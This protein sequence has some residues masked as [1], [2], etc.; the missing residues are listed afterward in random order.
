MTYHGYV[1]ESHEVQTDDGYLLTI[2]RIPHGKDNDDVTN[3]P[4]VLIMPGLLCSS[5]AFV[6]KGAES[7]TAYVL[8]NAG[9]DVWIGNAR[10]TTYSRKHISLNPDDDK[11]SFWDFRQVNRNPFLY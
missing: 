2:H 8:A 1:S 11:Q 10:G 5:S 7:G 9:Y 6:L 3:K 4:I